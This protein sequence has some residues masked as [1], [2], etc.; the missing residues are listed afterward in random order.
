[1]NK[2]IILK[3]NSLKSVRPVAWLALAVLAFSAFGNSVHA[4]WLDENF[5]SLG[6]GVN[7]TVGG[8]CVAAGTASYATGATGGGALKI[9]KAVGVAGTEVRWSLS[10]ASYSTPRPS[11]YITFKIQ[12]TPGAASASSAQMNFRLG[13]NDANNVSSSAATWFELRFINLPYTTA[14]VTGSNANLKITGNAGSGGQGNISLDNATSAVQIRI[15]YNTTGSAISYAHPGTGATLQL[16][17]NSFVVYGWK[18]AGEHWGDWKS[19]GYPSHDC[20]WSIRIYCRKNRF[21][22]RNFSVIRL[23]HR[24][25]LCGPFCSCFGSRHYER[26]PQPRHRLDILSRTQFY[27]R[28]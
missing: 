9:T 10:D 21:R 6:A 7:L 24:R 1:M 20:N 17:A 15:W 16:N 8:N 3:F 4:Q 25:H 12:Q 26:G 18:F 13:A 22:N 19:I 23:H 27:L 28:V 5:N 2:K 11:G 14:A